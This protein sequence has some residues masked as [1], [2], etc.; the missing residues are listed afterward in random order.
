VRILRR[1]APPSSSIWI[2][3]RTPLIVCTFHL[4]ARVKMKH[5]FKRLGGMWR[6]PKSWKDNA[7]SC[8]ICCHSR[9]WSENRIS[10]IKLRVQ[11]CLILDLRCRSSRLRDRASSS[12]DSRFRIPSVEVIVVASAHLNA[13]QCSQQMTHKFKRELLARVYWIRALQ[14]SWASGW[15]ELVR[16]TSRVRL[17]LSCTLSSRLSGDAK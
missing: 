5:S 10:R 16:I 12:L 2:W 6:A 15:G 9:K 3:A 11:V 7:S 13:I 14:A 1:A 4:W 17:K 8:W